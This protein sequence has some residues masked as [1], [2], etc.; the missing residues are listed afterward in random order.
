MF[1][2]RL[3]GALV[4]LA[5]VVVSQPAHAVLEIEAN[6]ATLPQTTNNQTSFNTV[7]FK[8]AFSVA[9][10]V[11]VLPSN[12]GADPSAVRIKNVTSTGF[13]I[14]QV[15]PLNLDGQHAAMT[16]HYLA[17]TPG[18]YVFKDVTIEAGTHDTTT[19][20]GGAGLGGGYDALSFTADFGSPP[21]LLTT[22]QTLNNESATDPPP[23]GPSDPWLTVATKAV[24][25]TGADV[26]LE[27]AET[28]GAAGTVDV[29]ESIG[30]VAISVGSGTLGGVDYQAFISGDII[31][32]WGNSGATVNY[33]SP[34]GADPL[35]LASL[36]TRDGADG[37]WLRR[38]AISETG[39]QLLLDED[40]FNDGERNHTTERASVVAFG[41]MFHATIPEPMTAL[42]GVMGLGALAMRR[43]RMA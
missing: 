20:I 9:P 21:A 23:S 4:A 15:E 43:R 11:I 6:M 2:I 31:D 33:P 5:L 38:G 30:Y 10:I 37:G 13:E 3:L 40:T 25:G 42:L 29:D 27:R 32:G 17:V 18:S 24:T 22:I 16:V 26:S 8:E 35:V 12:E 36:A 7:N 34:F 39:V 1:R 14:A 28:G 19:Q 41:Q